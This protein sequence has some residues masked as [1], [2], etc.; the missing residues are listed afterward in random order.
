MRRTCTYSSKLENIRFHANF[1]KIFEI[2]NFMP[3]LLQKRKICENMRKHIWSW[4]SQDQNIKL[5]NTFRTTCRFA[6]FAEYAANLH[7]VQSSCA[8]LEILVQTM[9]TVCRYQ[10]LLCKTVQTAHKIVRFTCGP[11]KDRLGEFCNLHLYL[12]KGKSF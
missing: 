7:I 9:R 12:H 4:P 8:I 5:M 11:R 10:A 1:V 6:H 2:P 3:A